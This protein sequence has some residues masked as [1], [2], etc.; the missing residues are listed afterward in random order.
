MFFQPTQLKCFALK[1]YL[2]SNEDKL[3]LHITTTECYY[4][5]SDVNRYKTASL[6]TL[7]IE[8]LTKYYLMSTAKDSDVTFL[9]LLDD[10]Q[11]QVAC[12]R[13]LSR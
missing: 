11:V 13:K 9:K 5:L 2:I 1:C 12:N 6:C 8:N 4:H 3:L 7:K 10:G